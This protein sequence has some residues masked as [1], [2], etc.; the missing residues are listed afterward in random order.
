MRWASH[1]ARFARC[2]N[3][4]LSSFAR[5]V[6]IGLQGHRALATCA[7][8]VRLCAEP[9]PAQG[10]VEQRAKTPGSLS[11]VTNGEGL[12]DADAAT[13]QVVAEMLESIVNSFTTGTLSLSE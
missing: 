2:R 11:R 5:Q 3:A 12:E 1:S 8:L 10:F 13:Q 4:H 6:N 9:R 7:P